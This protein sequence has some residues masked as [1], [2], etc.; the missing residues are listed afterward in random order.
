[1]FF[2]IY[3][4]LQFFLL[5]RLGPFAQV[6]VADDL[7][8]AVCCRSFIQIRKIKGKSGIASQIVIY[9]RKP[10]AAAGQINALFCD[11]ISDLWRGTFQ[12]RF[13]FCCDLVHT[14]GDPFIDNVGRNNFFSW[15]SG[16]TVDPDY[17]SGFFF[18]DHSV[19]P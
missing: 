19:F 5:Y 9:I 8:Q 6:S 3:A 14:V 12:K 1:M 13:H 18:S 17:F 11:M 7:F 2:I 10:C 16:N 4:P 15:K